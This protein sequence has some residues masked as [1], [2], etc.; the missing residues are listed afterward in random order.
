M[1]S[2]QTSIKAGILSRKV[3]TTMVRIQLRYIFNQFHP[4]DQVLSTAQSS[5][6]YS[7]PLWTMCDL[8]VVGKDKRKLRFE[9]LEMAKSGLP[10][11]ISISA[12]SP[13][14]RSAIGGVRNGQ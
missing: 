5:K 10:S 11:K 6:C 14:V 3:L 13:K 12:Q 8:G 4:E 1:V 9:T 7:R 2:G